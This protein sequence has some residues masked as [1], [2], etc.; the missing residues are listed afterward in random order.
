M[1]DSSAIFAVE[2]CYKWGKVIVGV[3][4]DWRGSE[5]DKDASC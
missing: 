3:I 4:E 2:G 1:I 5:L